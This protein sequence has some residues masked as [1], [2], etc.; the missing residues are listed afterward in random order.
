[1]SLCKPLWA[2]NRQ[3]W[4]QHRLA[5][6][7]SLIWQELQG[8]LRAEPRVFGSINDANPAFAQ[9]LEDA[10]V[11]RLANE[12]VGV[13][14]SAVMLGCGRRGVNESAATGRIKPQIRLL[15]DNRI[16]FEVHFGAPNLTGLA[17]LPRISNKETV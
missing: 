8:E 15:A 3:L 5:V 17:N 7:G 12:R 4:I 6:P 16:A 1:M 10:V 14:H 11:S 9:L 2:S 13:Q